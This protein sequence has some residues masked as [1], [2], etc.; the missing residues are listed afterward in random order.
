MTKNEKE[1][2]LI[3]LSRCKKTTCPKCV[4]AGACMWVAEA[5]ACL[6]RIKE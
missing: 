2:K 1:I 6:D 3:M 4:Y 5:K